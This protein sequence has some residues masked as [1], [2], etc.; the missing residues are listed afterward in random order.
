MFQSAAFQTQQSAPGDAAMQSEPAPMTAAGM[1]W[2][3]TYPTQILVIAVPV[4]SG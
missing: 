2:M 1:L 4:P 3:S